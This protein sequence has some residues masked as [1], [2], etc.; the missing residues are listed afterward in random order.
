MGIWTARQLC[1]Q[2]VIA[3]NPTGGATIRLLLA[4]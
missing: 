2:L 4:L 3:D 1:D